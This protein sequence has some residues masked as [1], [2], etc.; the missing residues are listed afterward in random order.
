[1]VMT[2]TLALRP[3]MEYPAPKPMNMG[4]DNIERLG[5]CAD[6]DGGILCGIALSIIL[7][8]WGGTL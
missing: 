8:M 3:R 6:C 1:M 5:L 2:G 4:S 7:W